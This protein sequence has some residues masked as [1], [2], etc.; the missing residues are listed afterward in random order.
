MRLI[1][2]LLAATQFV[3]VP[4][5]HGQTTSASIAEVLQA[6][7]Q[8]PVI[9]EWQIRR[10]V[11][12]Q[13][14]KLVLP[15]RAE[16]WTVES[17]KLRGRIIETALHGWP[18]KWID[19]PPVFEEVGKILEGDG[20][21]LRKFRYEI[22]SGFQS[23]ALLYQP[24]S[25]DAKLPAILEVN[26]HES[27]GKAT[28]YIQ[29]RCI[30]HARQGILALNLEWIGM[31][32]L[33]VP[34]NVHWNNSYLDLAGANG[35]GL[36]YLAMRKGLDYLWNLPNVD[37]TRIGITGLSGGGWQSI[38]LGALDQRIFAAVPDAGYRSVLSVGGADLIGDNEQ[39]ATD[40]NAGS[41]YMHLTALRAPRPTM[42]IYNENDNCC[43]RA[44]RMKP[45][46]FDSVRPFFELYGK[47][48]DFYWYENTNPGDHNY[49]LDNRRHSSAFFE[50]Y[51]HLPAT[52]V[53]APADQDIRSSDQLKVGL[54]ENNLTILALA[55]QFA[56]AIRREPV[57]SDV[58]GRKAWT[59]SQR[60]LLR[61][62]LRYK[63]VSLEFKWPLANTYGAGL[64]TV[65]YRFD[66]D[67]GLSAA[68]TWLRSG[69]TSEE[70]PWTIVLND[71]GKK[72]SSAIVSD[73]VNREQ[74][75]LALDLLFTGDAAPAPYYFPVYDRMLATEGRRSLSIEVSQLVAVAAWLKKTTKHTVGRIEAQGIRSQAVA[76]IAAA[77]DPTLFSDVAVRSGLPSWSEIFSRPI[78]YQDAPELFCLDLFRRFDLPQLRAMAELNAAGLHGRVRALARHVRTEPDKC[79]P[80]S[81]RSSD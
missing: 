39:S 59:Q 36:F 51:F 33:A 31:G 20:Y 25:S 66:F 68:G 64:Q 54:P 38:V 73:L 27:E 43:F 45:L 4:L 62:T 69:T 2:V 67:D 9:T 21:R 47:Q 72:A 52:T 7:L 32:E 19:A 28:E 1:A 16:G 79:L 15:A 3:P 53:E 49:Q 60:D 24:Q 13:V 23:T 71:S 18:Q 6:H 37:R 78:R 55:R 11:V 74:Q 29:K 44:P 70:A 41:D 34:E 40:L 57:P 26:G 50:K 48:D 77:L 76:T 56:K 5:L 65:G 46:L 63:P 30:N 81:G 14:P 75:V 12:R 10:Y 61:E 42:L 22:V 17:K 58:Q 35:L 80:H 8:D